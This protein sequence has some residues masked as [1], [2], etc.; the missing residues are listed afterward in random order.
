M[1]CCQCNQNLPLE[2]FIEDTCI[3]VGCWC[4]MVSYTC[5]SC[6]QPAIGRMNSYYLFNEYPKKGAWLCRKCQLQELQT[7]KLMDEIAKGVSGK[8]KNQKR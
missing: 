7:R 8:Y 6:G 5:E 1:I 3:C 2:L 4:N